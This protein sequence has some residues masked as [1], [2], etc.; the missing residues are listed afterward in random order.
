MA[1][2]EEE[3]EE[4]AGERCDTDKSNQ[5]QNH[6]PVSSSEGHLGALATKREEPEVVELS[7]EDNDNQ[8]VPESQASPAVLQVPEKVAANDGGSGEAS[9]AVQIKPLPKLPA[10]LQVSSAFD[11]LYVR[12]RCHLINQCE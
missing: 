5:E 2:E 6:L 10:G 11:L 9:S 3:K 4:G 1:R 8:Q 7:D 12:K